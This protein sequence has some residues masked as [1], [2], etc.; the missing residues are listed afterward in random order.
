MGTPANVKIGVCGVTFDGTDLGYTSGGVSVSY[1]ADT[2]EVTVDQEA[3]P[4]KEIVTAQSFEV[5]VPMA[6]YDLSKLVNVFP[7]ATLVSTGDTDVLELGGS[8]TELTSGTDVP[9]VLTPTDGGPTEVITIT[10]A[11]AM[12]SV[13]FTFEKDNA[14][15]FEVTFKAMA[16]NSGD[17]WVKFG[18]GAA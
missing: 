18:T 11:V 12:P 3:F 15:V 13:D 1:S 5:T 8:V 14:R 10:N 7:D 2:S 6:E 17:V 16:P 9:L 4:I